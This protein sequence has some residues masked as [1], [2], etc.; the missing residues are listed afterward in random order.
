MGKSQA[1]MLF[2][3]KLQDNSDNDE[4]LDLLQHLDYMPLV[5]SQAAAYIQQRAP[6]MTVSKYLKDFQRSKKDKANLLNIAIRD[7][8]RDSQ[9]LHSILTTWQISFEHIQE[10]RPLAAQLLSLMSFF[11]RQGIP[12]ELLISR[13]RIGD[14]DQDFKDNIHILR[15]YS[16]IV[17]GTR[18]DIF[19]MHRLVQLATKTW[20]ERDN[21]LEKCKEVYITI[22]ARNFPVG[23]HKNW[24]RC[25]ALFP[26]TELVIG[27]RPINKEFLQDWATVLFNAAW[28]ARQVG[29]YNKAEEIDRRAL[30]E[31]EIVLGKEHPDTLTSV[32]NL[33]LMLRYQGKYEAA[34]ELNRR[35]LKG[36][37]IILGKEH[38]NTLMSVSNLA[39][40]LRYQGKYKAAK[41]LNRRALERY[42][43]VLGKEHLDI[44]ISVSNL[45]L[46]L[47]DQGKDKAVK[48]LN[49]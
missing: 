38:L 35:A 1:L 25:Q 28:Y 8:R 40:M 5:I 10:V 24:E 29:K 41:E 15:S 18:S 17:I 23:Q 6:Q 21:K 16:L 46:V 44:L 19:E 36:Y 27:Y 49:Q 31:R 13:R 43:T 22:M 47:R 39:L 14:S 37:K 7:R 4:V 48:E 45:A 33:A 12:E 42:K 9:T 34:E 3:K 26:H 2:Q 20:L 32:S 11:D 30:E